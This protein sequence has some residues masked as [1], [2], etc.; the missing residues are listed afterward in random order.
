LQIKTKNEEATMQF[1]HGHGPEITW[2]Y[3]RSFPT[4]DR[5]PSPSFHMTRH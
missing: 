3:I 4:T 1:L 5:A 2:Q